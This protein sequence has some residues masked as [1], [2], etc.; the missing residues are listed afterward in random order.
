MVTARDGRPT[1]VTS[2]P[3]IRPATTPRAAR[4]TKMAS[5][6]QCLLH[7]KPSVALD[8][9]RVAAT[10]RSIS[11]LMTMSVIGSAMIAISPEETPRLKKFPLV[12]NWDEVRP[13]NTTTATATRARP[14]SQRMAGCSAARNPLARRGEAE[15]CAPVL[16]GGVPPGAV[17]SALRVFWSGSN[18]GAPLSQRG[19]ELDRDEAVEADGH[20]EQEAGDGQVPEWRDSEH[21]QRRA[22]G[23]EQKRPDSCADGAAAP[24]EDRHPADNDGGDHRQFVACPRGGVNGLV[25]RGPQHAGQPCNAA[26]D[27]EGGEDPL[28]DGD[29]GQARGFRVRADRIKL[30]PGSVGTQVVRS[31]PDYRGYH[32]GQVGNPEHVCPGDRGE[33]GRKCLGDHLVPAHD[34]D[35]DSADDV[36][37]GQRDHEAWHPADGHHEPV[38]DAAAETD[39]QAREEDN[40]D[41]DTGRVPEEVRRHIR[42]QAQYRA[43]GQVH[44][45]AYD[46]HRLAEREESVHGGVTEDELDVRLVD[47]P[48][49]DARRDRDE[50]DQDGNDAGLPD[51]GNPLGELTRAGSGG[52]AGRIPALGQRCAH[53]ACPWSWPVAA[54]MIFSSETSAWLNSAVSRPSRITRIRSPMRSTSGSSEEIIK[55]AT[56]SLASCNSS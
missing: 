44:V 42:R 14:V 40:R 12:R 17:P 3:L 49:L 53:S 18:A 48:R 46:H 23:G 38:G 39:S 51:P 16:P 25:L 7:R 4:M 34:E 56:P 10:D 54:A 55:T 33:A 1:R 37:S 19:H 52:G 11:P 13:P 41:G 15:A 24:A 20:Q 22:D 30:A 32:D 31:G 21:V 28:A 2:R 27:R 35:V 9:P 43:D 26:A 45:P 6:G 8:M 50:H 29:T 36:E 5:M 47:E